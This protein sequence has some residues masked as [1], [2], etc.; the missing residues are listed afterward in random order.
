MSR[1]LERVVTLDVDPATALFHATDVNGHALTVDMAVK[2]GQRAGRG[3]AARDLLL[4]ALVGCSGSSFIKALHD[5]EQPV[6]ALSVRVSG[7][8]QAEPPQVFRAID[9]LF[10]VSG[11][12][13]DTERVR[14]ALFTCRGDCSI[15]ATLGQLA[16]I[17]FDVE[18][19][20][21]AANR[22][23]AIV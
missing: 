16:E 2:L 22:A 11:E 23:T 14:E 5:F 15:A 17:A 9:V 8:I 12:R 10:R 7:T 3:Y 19:V 1:K 4:V 13:L 21:S 18:I 20:P 6:S